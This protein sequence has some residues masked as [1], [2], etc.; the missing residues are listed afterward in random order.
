MDEKQIA[1][2]LKQVPGARRGADGVIIGDEQGSFY[3]T[4]IAKKDDDL[5]DEEQFFAPFCAKKEIIRLRS[6]GSA[7]DYLL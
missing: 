2:L 5:S 1:E 3:I 4:D 6:L 7:H